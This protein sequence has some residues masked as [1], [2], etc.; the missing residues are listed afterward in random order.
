MAAP[1]PGLVLGL[2]LGCGGE[3]VPAKAPATSVSISLDATP[4]TPVAPGGTVLF[5]ATVSGSVNTAVTWTV[6]GVAGGNATTGT[7]TGTGGTATYTA[8]AAAGS[9]TVQATSVADTAKSASMDVTVT[10]S[11][12]VALNPAAVTLGP[13]ASQPF[14]ATV[15]GSANTAV[16]WTVDG[17]TGGNAT[18]GT[19]AGTG[20]TVT[21]TAPAATGSHTVKATSVV[22]TAKGAMA[23]VTVADPGSV[24]AVA[25]NPG[26]LSLAAGAQGQFTATV[27]G[28]GSYSTAVTWS[29]QRGSIT[30][31]GVYTA[32]ATS[33]SDLVTATSV[34]NSAKTGVAAVTV[35]PV[36]PGKPTITGVAVSPA[37]WI[38]APSE[39]KSF[40]ATVAGT[41]DYSR[42]VVWSAQRGSVD[43]KGLYTAPGS[44]GSDIV[45]ATSSA[46]ATKS[47]VS[48][49]SVQSGCAPAP[50]SD[51]TVNV[52]NAPYGAKGDGSAD[53]TAAIQA[54]VNAMAGSGGTVLI[55]DG[56]Y[57][58]NAL[59]QGGAG[60]LVGSNL[61]LRLGS[62]AVLKA[63]PNA[64]SN[65]AILS[66]KNVSR[67]TIAGGTLLG[68]RGAHQGTGGEWGMGISISGSDQVVVDGVTVQD[69][70]GDGF[71]VGFQST[72]V[73]LCNVTSDHNRRQGLSITS[74]DGLVVK[75]STFKNTTGTPPE[76][77]INVE[78]N[79]GET[80]NNVT[81]TGCTL[82]NN[83]GGGFQCG[84]PFAGSAFGTNIVFDQN[85]VNGNG[86]SPSGGGYKQ[87]VNITVF[88][89]V[90]V[91]NNQVLNNTGEGI[92]LTDRATH[93]TVKGNTVKGTLRVSGSEYWTGV[94]ILISDCGGSTITGNTVTGNAGPGIWQIVA[95]S[96]VT[97]SDNT[98]SGNGS[99]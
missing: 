84:T 85:L 15:S 31:G 36:E 22:A 96:T 3:S 82:T 8:P 92:R 49:I 51:G 41:G 16:T 53:D 76:T 65:Y 43:A 12:Q 29:A 80:A 48:A 7:L 63:I 88:D 18:T 2:A 10:A 33:G 24:T 39:Q 78:P 97:V 23:A 55:P 59:A 95:D 73:T 40:T 30:S 70:W 94:G 32:P 27:S 91:T 56:T 11:V 83:A 62:G 25:V 64:A 38:L 58:V 1:V 17:V 46:D 34:Q 54:A 72:R 74:V 6:D 90:Q 61:T 45:T 86:L 44:S 75:Q 69:C 57:M 35:T 19:L 5:T 68:D 79:S 26:T 87:A 71:Y 98:V 28:T 99:N 21:Y 66:V 20:G 9:H 81:I 4:K 50:A 60:I 93:T 37:S 52:R 14:T 67:V 47:G 89:G 42:S 13:G 77:G